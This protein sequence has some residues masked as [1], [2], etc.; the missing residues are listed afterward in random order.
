M[1][2]NIETEQSAA[3]LFKNKIKV[4]A[5]HMLG[6]KSLLQQCYCSNHCVGKQLS[7]MILAKEGLTTVSQHIYF[8]GKAF[9]ALSRR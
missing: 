5:V 9:S 4:I 6:S 3:R 7:I 2:L 1:D 8:Y